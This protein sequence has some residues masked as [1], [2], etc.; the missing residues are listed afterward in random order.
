[1]A[2]DKLVRLK[3]LIPLRLCWRFL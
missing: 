2:Q 3:G 1:M